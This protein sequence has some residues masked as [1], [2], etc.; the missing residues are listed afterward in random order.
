MLPPP[1]FK[2]FNKTLNIGILCPLDKTSVPGIKLELRIRYK[3]G[4]HLTEKLFSHPE[5]SGKWKKYC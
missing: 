5:I 1:N 3:I 2:N 4:F